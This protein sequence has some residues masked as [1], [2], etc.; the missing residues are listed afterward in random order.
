MTHSCSLRSNRS[1]QVYLATI[2]LSIS[3]TST[4]SLLYLDNLS[5]LDDFSPFRRL[6]SVP[7]TSLRPDDLS[8]S[9]ASNP[10]PHPPPPT[11]APTYLIRNPLHKL[12][13]PPQ[14]NPQITTYAISSCAPTV[15]NCLSLS[16]SDQLRREWFRH[17]LGPCGA[18]KPAL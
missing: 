2:S 11:T 9:T 6:L 5:Y 14:L 12:H 7:T 8:T 18:P 1:A 13:L 3:T 10:H 4:T 16:S 15:T 17:V